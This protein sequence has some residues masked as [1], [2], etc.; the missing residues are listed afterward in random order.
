M[1]SG[2]TT[3]YFP[4]LSK[5]KIYLTILSSLTINTF[6]PP[7]FLFPA[8]RGDEMWN[9]DGLGPPLSPFPCLG[10]WEKGQTMQRTLI[11]MTTILVS[12]NSQGGD[13]DF[14]WLG[15]PISF[16]LANAKVRTWDMSQPL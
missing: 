1:Q 13:G 15:P 6:L 4:F 2:P 8:T 10:T 5:D 7:L 9:V 16:V 11:I 14:G 12:T 3:V